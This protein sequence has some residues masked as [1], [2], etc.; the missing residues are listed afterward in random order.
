MFEHLNSRS[1]R[2]L[3]LLCVQSL[4]RLFSLNF[5]P[6]A[7]F[8]NGYPWN[9]ITAKF[10][11]TNGVVST[12][13]L[14]IASPVAG[15]LL[16]GTSDLKQRLWDMQADVKPIFDMS[17]TALA[18]GFVVNPFV[19][20]GALVTQYILRNPIEKAFTAQYKVTGFWDDP[21]LE[22]LGADAS[23]AKAEATPVQ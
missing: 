13:D 9:A 1:A 20:I 10:K 2:L 7:V 15:I 19:G 21:K 3:E 14:T 8:Q 22:P 6:G 16:V 5:K 4:Q 17:G 12:N 11:I 18:T 23:P